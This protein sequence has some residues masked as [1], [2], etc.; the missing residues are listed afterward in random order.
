MKLFKIILKRSTDVNAQDKDGR[1]ALHIAFYRSGHKVIKLLLK[2]ERVDV[3]V[4]NNENRTA[5]YYCLNWEWPKKWNWQ[6][7]KISDDLSERI[8]IESTDINAQ[9][10]VNVNT[11][12][13]KGRTA[14]HLVCRSRDLVTPRNVES[15]ESINTDNLIKIIVK[16]S[17]DVNAQDKKGDT[18]LHIA[19]RNFNN[20]AVKELLKRKDLDVDIENNK[21]ETA[22][23]QSNVRFCCIFFASL[24]LPKIYYTRSWRNPSRYRNL[25][26]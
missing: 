18:A 3:N 9:D 16:Q 15:R 1:T 20:V 8:R 25:N 12:N 5:L 10:E 19:L 26:H 21:K 11:K 6:N 13:K 23:H 22:F 17:T 24:F 2:D 4:K 7:P 14:L